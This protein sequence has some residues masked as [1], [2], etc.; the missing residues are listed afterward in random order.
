MFKAYGKNITKEGYKAIKKMGKVVTK[1]EIEIV[2]LT[3]YKIEDVPILKDDIVLLF[4]EQVVKWC[5]KYSCKTKLELPQIDK[6]VPA[7]GD[8]ESR[9][10]AYEML[11]DLKTKIETETFDD[12]EKLK[13]T[14][15]LVEDPLPSYSCDEVKAL[16]KNIKDNGITE[17]KGVTEEGKS[18]RISLNA[19]EKD[20]DICLTF[21]ELWHLK[22]LKDLLHI[23]ELKF[24]YANAVNNGKNNTNKCN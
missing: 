19:K 18:I 17:W 6:L 10:M 2:D 20:A 7:S 16:E 24:V 23:K 21:A 1:E 15:Q 22:V 13:Q 3:S 5:S 4:G 11:L 9:E 14:E 12:T 8:T